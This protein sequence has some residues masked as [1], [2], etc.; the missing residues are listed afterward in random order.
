[1]IPAKSESNTLVIPQKM[2]PKYHKIIFSGKCTNNFFYF[3]HINLE[4]QK[5]FYSSFIKSNYTIF[6]GR[7]ET[8][9]CFLFTHTPSDSLTENLYQPHTEQN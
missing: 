1:M 8:I 9:P 3:V 5:C 4:I 2:I 6:S 7:N